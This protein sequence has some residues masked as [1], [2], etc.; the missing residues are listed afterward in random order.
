MTNKTS[1]VDTLNA[2]LEMNILTD[3]HKANVEKLLAS[4][5]AKI[6]KNKKK[7]EN[8]LEENAKLADSIISKMQNGS[9]YRTS[10][11]GRLTEET[12][13]FSTS[14]L[15]S[16]AKNFDER[17]TKSVEKGVTYYSLA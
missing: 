10:D 9:K 3:D 16:I 8:L 2:I 14:K 12:A 15:V 11:L 5:Q 13:T 6:A 17:V 1:Y 7:S 4:C